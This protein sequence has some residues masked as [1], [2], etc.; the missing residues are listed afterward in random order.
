MAGAL[1]WSV[2]AVLD[3][4]A[5]LALGFALVPLVVYLIAPLAGLVARKGAA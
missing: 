4:I 2:T 5:G 3:G 1:N